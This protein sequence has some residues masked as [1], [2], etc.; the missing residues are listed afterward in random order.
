MCA[1][2]RRASVRATPLNRSAPG[3]GLP[4]QVRA[5]TIV[6]SMVSCAPP[7]SGGPSATTSLRLS[8]RCGGQRSK[9]WTMTFVRMRAPASRHTRAAA[10]SSGN[11]LLPRTPAA[12][13]AAGWWPRLSRG[14]PHRQL[15]MDR[16]RRRWMRRSSNTWKGWGSKVVALVVGNAT[17][18]VDENG[19]DW[20]LN[21]ALFST[22]REGINTFSRKSSCK[23]SAASFCQPK[24][25]W[26]P[27]SSL[28]ARL[29]GNPSANSSQEGG[30][31]PDRVL[32]H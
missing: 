7:C 15:R 4:S 31:K 17:I 1:L 8:I 24:R 22:G 10:L 20:D 32:L 23:L 16:G 5:D 3:R 27:S 13:Q 25:N 14:Q 28:M 21:N 9:S 2:C 6:V 18:G 26:V 12:A 29:R 11:P 30:W 19:P